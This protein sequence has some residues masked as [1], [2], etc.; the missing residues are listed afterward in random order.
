[1][2]HRKTPE[3]VITAYHPP[4]QL[5]PSATVEVRCPYCT[6]LDRWRRKTSTPSTHVHG[7]GPAGVRADLGP[8]RVAHCIETLGL[9]YD[10]VDPDGLVPELLT[11]ESA[12]S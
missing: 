12:V 9:G 10:L 4:T 1:M 6:T 5:R 8:H 11:I 2:R 7:I 3:A